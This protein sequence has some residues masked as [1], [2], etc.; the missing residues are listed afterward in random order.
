MGVVR[1]FLAGDEIRVAADEQRRHREAV[2][3]ISVDGRRGI[4]GAVGVIGIAPSLLFQGL[5]GAR[6]VARA[7]LAAPFLFH[8]ESLSL[9]A[10]LP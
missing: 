2:E 9:R 1:A 5:A 10:R 8:G 4:G 6:Q 7:S 3:V